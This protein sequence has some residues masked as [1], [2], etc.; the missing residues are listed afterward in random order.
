MKKIKCFYKEESASQPGK[1]VIR[2]AHENFHLNYAEGSY[3][4]I[5][6]RLFGISYPQFLRMCRDC[7]G[8]EIIG[9]NSMYPV[10][11]FKRSKELDDLVEQLNSRANYILWERDHPNFEEHA[12]LV[13]ER[14]PIFYAEVTGNV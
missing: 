10:A 6:A 13:K 12:A 5:C 11:Y 1:F 4:L 3:N 14:N 7:F 9:K 2:P 8:A